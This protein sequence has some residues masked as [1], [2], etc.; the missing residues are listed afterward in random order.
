MEEP[1]EPNDLGV[2]IRRLRGSRRQWEMAE[3]ADMTTSSWSDYERGERQ[4]RPPQKMRVAKALGCT[5]RELEQEALA[6]TGERLAAEAQQEGV[7]EPEETS[8]SWLEHTARE[9]EE[10][11]Q[12][13]DALLARKKRLLVFRRML[14]A[15]PPGTPMSSWP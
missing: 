9:L 13:L 2:A 14:A 1:K 7:R 10:I 4:P 6:V 11:D 8:D 5:V 15:L 12:S 3:A